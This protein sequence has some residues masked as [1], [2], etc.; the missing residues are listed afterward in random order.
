MPSQPVS[1]ASIWPS[2]LA[3]AGV[4]Q[5]G[6]RNSTGELSFIVPDELPYDQRHWL[7]PLRWLR[8]ARSVAHAGRA[9]WGVAA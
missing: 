3:R 4:G 5:T 1:G 8:A 7:I 2:R 6:T 9:V